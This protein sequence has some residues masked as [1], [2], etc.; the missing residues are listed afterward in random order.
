M[1]GGLMLPACAVQP[2]IYGAHSYSCCA[3]IAANPTWHAGQSLTLHWQPTPPVGTTDANPHQIVLSLSLTGP[4]AS[5]DALKEAISRGS[6]PAGVTTV[7]AAPVS[8][9]DRTLEVLA[10]QLDLPTDLPPGYYN[11]ATRAAEAGQS[12]G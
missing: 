9:N 8:A 1:A 12:W 3:E 5:V 2:A 7:S 6:K 11:L 10:S 4:F